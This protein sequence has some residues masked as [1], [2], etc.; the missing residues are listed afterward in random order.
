MKK[1]VNI[2]AQNKVLYNFYPLWD[3]DN[4]RKSNKTL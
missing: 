3:A 2:V 4:I 1:V